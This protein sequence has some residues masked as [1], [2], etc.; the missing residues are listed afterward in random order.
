MKISCEVVEDLV[1][2]FGPHKRLR[3]V[4]PGGDPGSERAGTAVRLVVGLDEGW[5]EMSWLQGE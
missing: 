1:S 2:G 3:V 5:L 4:V